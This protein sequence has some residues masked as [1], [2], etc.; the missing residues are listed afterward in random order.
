[1]SLLDKSLNI[2]VNLKVL[3]VLILVLGG[4]LAGRYLLPS[5]EP[6]F[7]VSEEMEEDSNL[8]EV[9]SKST[10]SKTITAA[11]TVNSTKSTKQIS[12]TTEKTNENSTSKT[13]TQDSLKEEPLISGNYNN[14]KLEFTRTPS[15][16]WK[17]TWGKVTTIYYRITNNEGGTIKPASF[18]VSFEGYEKPKEANVPTADREIRSSASAEHGFDVSQQYSE[19]VTDP[20]NIEIRMVLLDGNQQVMATAEKAFNLKE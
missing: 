7:S 14:I 13:T 17:G 2:T 18:S 4:F 3:V 1:M 11:A 6:L 19:T 20:A 12:Q 10:S 8:E 5:E 15:F 9:A 16:E